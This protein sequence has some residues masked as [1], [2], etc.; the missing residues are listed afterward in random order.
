MIIEYQNTLNICYFIQL[1]SLITYCMQDFWP[2]YIHWKYYKTA[3]NFANYNQHLSFSNKVIRK[4]K[5]DHFSI[6]INEISI[7]L[8][9]LNVINTYNSIT[10]FQRYRAPRSI[11]QIYSNLC[12]TIYLIHEESNTPNMDY[13]TTNLELLTYNNDGL[14]LQ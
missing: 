13:V 9:C 5:I 12:G 4:D 14:L 8:A 7:I 1:S 6:C 2:K 3:D 10:N 11:F